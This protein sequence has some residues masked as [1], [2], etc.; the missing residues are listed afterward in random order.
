MSDF[1][2]LENLGWQPFFQS[3]LSLEELEAPE[4]NFPFRVIEQQKS[5]V[6]LSNGTNELSLSLTPSTPTLAVGDWVLLNHSGNFIRLLDRKTLFSR[7][8]AG[9][10]IGE[11]L[12]AANV[13]TAF[14]L[15]S[16]NDDFN[17]NRIERYL[18]LVNS[19]GSDAVILLSKSDLCDDADSLTQQVRKIAPHLLV[20]AINC[21]ENDEVEKLTPWLKEGQT[22]ALLGSSGVGKSTLTNTLAG[23][24]IQLTKDIREDDSKGRHTTTSRSLI[25]LKQGGLILDTPGMRE[26]N[27]YDSEEGIE[28]T[29]S[30]IEL[31]AEN[32]QFK[33]CQH[34]H[35]PACAVLNAVESGELEARRLENYQKLK[36]ENKRN[37][38][39]LSEKRATDKALG[40]FYKRTLG[41]SHKLKGRD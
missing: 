30:D 17:L 21:L 33:D 13:D 7:K 29:F 10:K 11:Q 1:K 32:C 23:G 15:C 34:N 36:R 4:E 14:I 31:L 27:I 22:V 20:E 19:T 39:S 35:E 16:L 38:A 40:K 26:I 9:T 28:E 5:Q 37:S 24:G 18:A 8:A 25:P 2:S 41:E 12:I 3:Q 6:N